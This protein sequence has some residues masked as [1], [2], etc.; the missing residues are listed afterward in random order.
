MSE[1]SSR[2]LSIALAL[3]ENDSFIFEEVNQ[4]NSSTRFFFIPHDLLVASCGTKEI[5]PH[6]FTKKNF[7]FPFS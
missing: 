5:L 6:D 1:G 7:F 2:D 4:Q 3:V